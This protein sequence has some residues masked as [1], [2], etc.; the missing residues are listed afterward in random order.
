MILLIFFSTNAIFHFAPSCI[1]EEPDD[2]SRN[3]AEDTV[4]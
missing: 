2:L 4:V 3:P 1:G